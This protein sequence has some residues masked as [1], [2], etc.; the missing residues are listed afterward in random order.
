MVDS[1]AEASA[2]QQVKGQ[3]G[4]PA[5]NRSR[6]RGLNLNQFS[7]WDVGSDYTCERL[8]GTG[9]YGKVALAK[10]KSTG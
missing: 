3:S 4:Q 7:D 10:R 9:S 2:S 5:A 6:R 8:L 1:N